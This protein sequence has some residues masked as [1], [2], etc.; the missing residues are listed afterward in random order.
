MCDFMNITRD[1]EVEMIITNL[2]K[3]RYSKASIILVYK[4]ASIFFS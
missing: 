4:V 3:Q 2:A 1:F